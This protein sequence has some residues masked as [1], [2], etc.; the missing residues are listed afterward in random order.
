MSATQKRDAYEYAHGEHEPLGR[1]D[2]VSAWLV[3][4]LCTAALVMTV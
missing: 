2:I 4:I 1:A 3:A